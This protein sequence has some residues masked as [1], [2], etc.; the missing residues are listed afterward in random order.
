MKEQKNKNKKQKQ[1]KTKQNKRR[2]VKEDEIRN[3]GDLASNIAHLHTHMTL[4]NQLFRRI[5][6]SPELSNQI[7]LRQRQEQE[8][9]LIS[10]E[11]TLKQVSSLS[12]FFTVLA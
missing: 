10:E 6:P 11:H 8:L 5:W 12:N 3:R 2:K 4:F 7:I 9:K 1:N